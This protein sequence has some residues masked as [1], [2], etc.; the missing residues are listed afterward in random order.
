MSHR[1][2]GGFEGEFGGL[3]GSQIENRYKLWKSRIDELDETTVARTKGKQTLQSYQAAYAGELWLKSKDAIGGGYADAVVSARCDESLSGT[4]TKEISF[5]G[6]R[7]TVAFSD[8][9][10]VTGP[11][12]IVAKINTNQG[13]VDL[14]AFRSKGGRFGI[15]CNAET[16]GLCAVEPS[17]SVDLIERTMKQVRFHYSVDGLKSRIKTTW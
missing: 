14:D 12:D 13:F 2:T 5:L 9:P 3:P 10:L 15:I 7:F 16:A 4:N 17:V 1:A 11:V 6:F 8:C